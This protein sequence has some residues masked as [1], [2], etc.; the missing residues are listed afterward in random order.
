VRILTGRIRDQG[1]RTTFLWAL[2]HAVRI[3]GGAPIRALSQI[4]PQVHLGG[5]HNRR[6]WKRLAAR[7]V[8]AVVNMRVEYDDREDGI[9]PERYLRLPTVDET[10]PTL[11]HLQ[12]GVAFLEREIADGGVVYVHCASGI[13][14]AATL[15]AAYLV[16][17][18]LSPEQAWLRIQAKRPFV[19]PEPS[20]VARLAEFSMRSGHRVESP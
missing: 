8:T 16:R 6:G 4:T 20:Q 19:R 15:V 18:G 5:Q 10:P 17:Q 13:G 14:R 9:A 12:Q 7:G 1:L 2:D 3:V 11:A